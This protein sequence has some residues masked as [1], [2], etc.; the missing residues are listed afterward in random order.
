[1]ITVTYENIDDWNR[2]VFK[3]IKSRSRFGSLDTLFP[4]QEG[5]KAVLQ[6]V[7]AEDLCYFGN[8]FN[9]EPMGNV[10][11]EP[12]EIITNK[13]AMRLSNEI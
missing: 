10:T 7:S 13:E 4:Y 9:C 2:P 11:E 3:S 12:I 1:M 5:E 6:E 8:R